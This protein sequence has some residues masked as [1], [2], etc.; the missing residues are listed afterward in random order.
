MTVGKP[1]FS[2][3]L[4]RPSS[5][6]VLSLI[7]L[8]TLLNSCSLRYTSKG[9]VVYAIFLIWPRDSVLEL[10]SPIP[11]PATQ[12]RNLKKRERTP[13]A[14]PGHMWAG[15]VQPDFIWKLG[16]VWK[17]SSHTSCSGGAL[18]SLQIL[19]TSQVFLQALTHC[20]T[21]TMG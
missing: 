13:R 20:S 19:A 7:G 15:K 6:L 8:F 3:C 5:C 12:V 2:C 21:Q 18:A 1:V 9:P 11:S 4:E 10:S 14:H 17:L 16:G